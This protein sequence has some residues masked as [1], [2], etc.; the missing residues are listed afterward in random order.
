M[1]LT[2]RRRR[3]LSLCFAIFAFDVG[4]FLVV[5][6]WSDYWSFNSLQ[7][8]WPTLEDYWEDPHFRGAITGLGLVNIYVALLEFFRILRGW[9]Q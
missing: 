9:R 4:V 7:A 3:L 8:Y 1:P 5:F 2:P 6:P